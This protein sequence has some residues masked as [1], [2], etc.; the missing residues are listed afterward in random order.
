VLNT[1]RNDHPI[2]PATISKLAGRRGIS[3]Q[4]AL[5]LLRWLGVPPE[6]FI[7]MPQPGTAIPLPLADEGHRLRWNLG[8]L[9][10]ALNVARTARRATWQQAADRL[11]CTPSQLTGLRVA[12][13]ATGM[14][15]A[16]RIT[17]ALRRPAADFVYLA[18]W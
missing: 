13:F 2:S 18:E 4:H 12:K 6:T 11:H 3:C 16:M 7:A 10:G 15:L 14:R 17:Q 1:R 9:Y 8:K 5:F